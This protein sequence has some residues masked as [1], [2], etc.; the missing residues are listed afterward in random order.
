MKR[1]YHVGMLVKRVKLWSENQKPR[2][3]Q[4]EK[5]MEL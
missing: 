5:E 1:R 4:M 3:H 2:F